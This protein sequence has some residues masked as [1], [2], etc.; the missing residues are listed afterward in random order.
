MPRSRK[1]WRDKL[2]EVRWKQTAI[3]TVKQHTDTENKMSFFP[4][5]LPGIVIE[6][7]LRRLNNNRQFY[8]EM[9][10]RFKKTKKDFATEIREKLSHGEREAAARMAHSMKSM[11]GSIGA[12]ELMKTSMALDEVLSQPERDADTVLREFETRLSIVISGIEDAFREEGSA[13]S[14]G[15]MSGKDYDPVA[16]KTL[17]VEIATLLGQDMGKAFNQ[18]EAL[19]VQLQGTVL[20]GKLE[21]VL[22][23]MEQFDLDRARNALQAIVE[24][25]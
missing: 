4:D 7:G 13:S 2:A 5:I 21:Q 18:L 11:A 14:I 9:L 17:A 24:T 6:A 25:C 1:C 8:C 12:E 23:A 15:T 20:R 10:L 19:K 16:V 22:Q 3:A